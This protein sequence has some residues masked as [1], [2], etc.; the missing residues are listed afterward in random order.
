MGTQYCSLLGLLILT[1]EYSVAVNHTSLLYQESY[2]RTLE[3][4]HEREVNNDKSLFRLATICIRKSPPL[5]GYEKCI[6]NFSPKT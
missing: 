5:W 2:T 3:Q 4:V 1:A 6:Q